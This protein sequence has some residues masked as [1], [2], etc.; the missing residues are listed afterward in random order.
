MHLYPLQIDPTPL[1]QLSIDIWETIT[2][3]TF[4]I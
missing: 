4:H 1:L 3:N 2:S